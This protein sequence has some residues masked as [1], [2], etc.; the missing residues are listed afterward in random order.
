MSCGAREKGDIQVRYLEGRSARQDQHVHR[1]DV[2]YALEE[3]VA[4]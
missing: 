3:N 1:F 2:L 4:G